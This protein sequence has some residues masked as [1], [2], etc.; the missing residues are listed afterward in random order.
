MLFE[1]LFGVLVFW[2]FDQGLKLDCMG[3][4]NDSGTGSVRYPGNRGGLRP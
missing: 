3:I 2:R 1:A 4:V